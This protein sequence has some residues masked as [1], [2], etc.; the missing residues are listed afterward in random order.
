MSEKI[1]ILGLGNVLMKDEG[2]GV[3]IVEEIEKRNLP[4]NVEVIDGG[5]ASLDIFLSLKD[6]HKLIIID[7]MKGGEKPGTVYRLYPGDLLATSKSQVSL[8]Q[9][10]LVDTLALNEKMGNVPEETII[11]GIEPKEIDWGLGVTS[12]IKRKIPTIIDIV[13]REVENACHRTETDK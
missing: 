4:D 3:Y 9:I 12:D 6:I 13:L 5:T 11:I 2:I 7:A 8:H 1:V 10:N